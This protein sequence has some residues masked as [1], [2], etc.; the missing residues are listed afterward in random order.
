MENHEDKKTKKPDE[1]ITI[2]VS[3]HL[4]I[5]DKETGQTLVKK[6]G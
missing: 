5:R 1:R 2:T 3:G 4:E 6:R